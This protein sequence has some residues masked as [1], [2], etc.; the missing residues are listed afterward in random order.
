MLDLNVPYYIWVVIA[1]VLVLKEVRSWFDM[2][3]EQDRFEQEFKHQCQQDDKD[4]NVSEAV[5]RM[6]S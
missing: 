1:L 5:K 4:N 6:F 2:V 3:L